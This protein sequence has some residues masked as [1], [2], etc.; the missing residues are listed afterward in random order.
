MLSKTN[1]SL[2]LQCLF[3]SDPCLPTINTESDQ[4]WVLTCRVH[5]RKPKKAGY[6]RNS[7]RPFSLDHCPCPNIH[8]QEGNCFINGSTWPRLQKR[9]V[10]AMLPSVAGFFVYFNF[11]FSSSSTVS[12]LHTINFQVKTWCGNWSMHRSYSPVPAQLACIHAGII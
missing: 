7:I 8:V 5:T 12:F 10:L 4:S 3:Q 2:S 9:V 11:F 6:N 1:V